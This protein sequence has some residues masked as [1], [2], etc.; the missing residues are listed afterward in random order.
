MGTLSYKVENRFR[1]IYNGESR[2]DLIYLK[3][4]Y[5]LCIFLQQLEN[6]GIDIT[7]LCVWS[8]EEIDEF[9]RSYPRF[10]KIKDELFSQNVQDAASFIW[11]WINQRIVERNYLDS[12]NNRIVSPEDLLRYEHMSN[13]FLDADDLKNYSKEELIDIIKGQGRYI[14]YLDELNKSPQNLINKKPVFPDLPDSLHHLVQRKR[15]EQ[16]A[17]SQSTIMLTED[18]YCENQRI[19]EVENSRICPRKVDSIEKMPEYRHTILDFTKVIYALYKL[20][21]FKKFDANING[22]NLNEQEDA[23][24]KEIMEVFGHAINIEGFGQKY[25]NDFSRQFGKYTNNGNSVSKEDFLEIFER[26]K[27]VMEFEYDKRKK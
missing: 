16:V 26:M 17:A 12:D 1:K 4:H 10:D 9:L 3:L 2:E 25:N 18:R 22:N 27:R 14:D 5:V 11:K 8:N 23:T 19:D 7:K 13:D 21:Y 20:K 15:S 24:V 6:Q